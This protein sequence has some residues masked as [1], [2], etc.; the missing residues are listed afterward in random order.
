MWPV[1]SPRAGEL[2]FPQWI[3]HHPASLQAQRLLPSRACHAHQHHHIRCHRTP[4][5]RP[6]TPHAPAARSASTV[7]QSGE[8]SAGKWK[9]NFK[10]C[11]DRQCEIVTLYAWQKHLCFRKLSFNSVAKV[12]ERAWALGVRCSVRRGSCVLRHATHIFAFHHPRLH[13]SSSSSSS[14][15]RVTSETPFNSF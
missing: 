15:A 11:G 1:T 9:F 7:S 6:P 5:H 12:G 3:L 13:S 2:L 4:P 14:A 8:K 10:R